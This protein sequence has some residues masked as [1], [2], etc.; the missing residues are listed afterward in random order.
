MSDLRATFVSIACLLR[1]VP[2]FVRASPRTPLRALGIIALDTLHVLRYSRP[3]TAAR[4][5]ELAMFLDL[6]GCTNAL[7]DHKTLC[8]EEYLAIKHRLE[9]AGLGTCLDTYLGR[10]RELESR[11]PSVGGDHRHFAEVRA[12]REGVARLSIETAAAIALN[13][14]DCEVETLFRLLMQC[15]IIDDALDYAEDAAAGLPSFL[16]ATASFPEAIALTAEAARH[17]ATCRSTMLPLRITLGTVSAITRLVLRVAHRRRQQA[18]AFA[19][20]RP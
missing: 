20:T 13:A 10:L 7:W 9:A 14:G 5:S 19:P 17:Y 18:H 4:V 11:R 1:G 16:T 6:E 12:Y 8:V 15:Q 3:L 2:L